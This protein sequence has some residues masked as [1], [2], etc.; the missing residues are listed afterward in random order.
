MKLNLATGEIFRIQT[1]LKEWGRCIESVHP[2]EAEY[3]FKIR[4]KIDR[5][6][7]PVEEVPDEKTD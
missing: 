3:M 2:E 1:A 6:M 4:D 7:D 5:Q